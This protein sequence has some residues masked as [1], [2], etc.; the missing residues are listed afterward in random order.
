MW[1]VEYISHLSWGWP[2]RSGSCCMFVP[3]PWRTECTFLHTADRRC[4]SRCPSCSSSRS[5]RLSAPAWPCT[6]PH[7]ERATRRCWPCDCRSPLTDLCS[8]EDRELGKE[9]RREVQFKINFLTITLVRHKPRIHTYNTK[10]VV[11]ASTYSQGT[12]IRKRYKGN[13]E[14]QLEAGCSKKC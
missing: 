7:Q 4:H 6:L 12:W 8:Q 5:L 13:M 14:Q 9:E 1:F 10:T 3:R 11:S 2:L